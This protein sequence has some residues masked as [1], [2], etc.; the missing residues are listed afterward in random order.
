MRQGAVVPH[1]PGA[2][3]QEG[4]KASSVEMRAPQAASYA[5]DAS[6]R[7]VGAAYQ[8]IGSLLRITRP[9]VTTGS[10]KGEVG[11]EE[12]GR[13]TLQQTDGQRSAAQQATS[14]ECERL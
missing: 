1:A 13:D 7:G 11:A 4:C 2:V 3:T 10:L 8:Q 6:Q 12:G 5:D 9:T 14:Q